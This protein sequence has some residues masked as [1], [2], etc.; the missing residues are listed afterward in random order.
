LPYNNE[1]H[2][3]IKNIASLWFGHSFGVNVK[4]L[5]KS[6]SQLKDAFLKESKWKY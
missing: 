1:N 4:T 2:S 3:N 6:T 5:L